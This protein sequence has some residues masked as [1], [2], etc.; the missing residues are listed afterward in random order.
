[1]EHPN[2][3]ERMRELL[4]VLDGSDVI[5]RNNWEKPSQIQHKGRIDLV[6][7]FAL[8]FYLAHLFFLSLVFVLNHEIHERLTAND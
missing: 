8:R 1:M 2:F 6:L 4:R 3:S 7:E 5:F